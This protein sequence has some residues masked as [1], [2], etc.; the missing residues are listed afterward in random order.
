MKLDLDLAALDRLKPLL[1]YPL[2]QKA[3]ALSSV[4]LL[5]LLGYGFIFWQPVQDQLDELNSAIEEQRQILQKNQV[6]AE[7]LELKKKEYQ[8]LVKDLQVTLA[9]LPKKSQIDELLASVSWAGKDAGL[10]F[11]K[12]EPK[13][14]RMHEIYAEV[15]VSVGMHGT[16]RQLMSFLKRV[17]EMPR[18]ADVKHLII[19]PDEQGS[20]LNIEGEVVTYRFI[21]AGGQSEAGTGQGGRE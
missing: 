19:V 15:P 5:L 10:D 13:E 4:V 9:M 2:W 17:G 12:F 18:I 1:I 11:S 16:F 6:I 8:K 7:K 14:E 21:S 3:M 20:S